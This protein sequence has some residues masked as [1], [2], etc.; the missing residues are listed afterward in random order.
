MLRQSVFVACISNLYGQGTAGLGPR[1]P[2]VT[3]TF[4]VQSNAVSYNVLRSTT[5]G[6]PY[7]LVGNS[8]TTTFVDKTAG[9]ANGGTYY[10][11]VQPQNSGASTIC[12][13]NQ[14]AITIP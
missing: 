3:L 14:V 9:L 2:Y 8:A 7:S 13:S 11:I 6:G 1:K 5:N 12:A 4:G 10:Y